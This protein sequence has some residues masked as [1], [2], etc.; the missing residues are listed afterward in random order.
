MAATVNPGAT[1]YSGTL[2]SYLYLTFKDNADF[3][4][5]D[6]ACAYMKT[7]VRSTL[8]LDK[9]VYTQNPYE[10]YVVGNP[11]FA[12]GANKSKR[13]LNPASNKRTISGT[14][15]PSEWIEEWDKYAP[16]GTLTNLRAAP[17]IVQ[18]VFELAMNAAKE[19]EELLFWQGDKLSGTPALTYQDGLIKKIDTNSDGDIVFIP[20]I[21]AVLKT[22]IFDILWEMYQ[23]MPKK[24]RDDPNYKFHVSYNV[25]DLA[26]EQDIDVKKT[27]FGL[28]DNTFKDRFL[29]K[30]LVPYLGMPDTHIIGARTTGTEDS[31]FVYANYFGIDNE[32]RTIRIANTAN[33]G[34][35]IGYRVDF[36]ADV[37]YRNGV[38]MTV[39]KV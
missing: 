1:N 2:D 24:F 17:Q 9:L 36:M 27:S 13:E 35:E 19:Q 16:T 18:S 21:G 25:Y 14:I 15:D 31:N 20:S 3:L 30:R 38:D 37:Q 39:Y 33:L 7:G 32:F 11:T 22:N 34:T 29:N 26:N 10:P 28:L 23:G 5:S 12:S 6:K 8:Q 4:R